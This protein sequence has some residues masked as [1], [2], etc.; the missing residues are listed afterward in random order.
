[1][2]ENAIKRMLT[3]FSGIHCCSTMYKNFFK[4]AEQHYVPATLG[5]LIGRDV[6]ESKRWD[7]P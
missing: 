4:P 7:A 5:W 1:M 3:A 6:E 2:S